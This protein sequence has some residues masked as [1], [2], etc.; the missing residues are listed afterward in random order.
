MDLLIFNVD[1][2]YFERF[3]KNFGKLISIENRRRIMRLIFDIVR[4]G[5]YC[6]LRMFKYMFLLLLILG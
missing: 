4:V 2:I 6:F 3:V 5:F 1:I